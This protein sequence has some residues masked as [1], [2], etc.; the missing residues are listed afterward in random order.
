MEPAC[1]PVLAR[2][3]PLERMRRACFRQSG[4]RPGNSASST[5]LLAMALVTDPAL[6]P[7]VGLRREPHDRWR[8]ASPMPWSVRR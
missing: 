1:Q 6:K 8:P 5:V 2:A 7:R 4:H 3:V